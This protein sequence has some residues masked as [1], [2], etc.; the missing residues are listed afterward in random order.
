MIGTMNVIPITIDIRIVSRRT[1]III[2]TPTIPINNY[3]RPT[4]Y[5]DH[6]PRFYKRYIGY[7]VPMYI[8]YANP[9]Y[10]HSQQTIIDSQI[11]N[12]DQNITNLG[13]MVDVTQG[14]VINQFGSIRTAPT[15][16]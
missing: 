15:E 12:V 11:A 7:G 5:Y 16:T 8:K 4:M 6:K 9:F 1:P 2:P 14:S 10:Y 3:R 13:D